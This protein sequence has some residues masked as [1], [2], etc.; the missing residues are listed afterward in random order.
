MKKI[1][2]TGG[3]GFVG[4][5]L[6]NAFLSRKYDVY[7]VDDL[8]NGDEDNINK[9]VKYDKFDLSTDEIFIK[10]RNIKFDAV[11]HCAAQSSN[12][13]SFK[14]IKNDLYSNLV[15]TYNILKLCEYNSINRLI[16]T[17]SM[18]IYGQA[19]ILPTPETCEANPNSY[20][21]INKLFAEKYIRL[22]SSNSNINYTIF[23]LY[24]TYG[25][26]QNL[27]NRNQG[28]LS[29][30]LSY[31]LAN[32]ELIIKGSSDRKR[33]IICVS[34]VVDA[35]V[36]SY[37]S[38]RT[39]NKTYNL[40]SGVTISVKEIINLLVKGLV[41]NP[42][43][44]PIKYLDNTTGDPFETQADMSLLMSDLGWSPKLMPKE[45]IQKTIEFYN[46]K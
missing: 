2:I 6:C 28:L 9:A 21:A 22:F 37:D 8:S 31:I 36:M 20:Y 17:S 43:E 25:V 14:N 35:I 11:V 33:D 12:A 40:G 23:R 45:G 26:G 4:S 5:H 19:N 7:T 30:Y 34:D 15:A 10:Y 18:S 42:N 46:Q 13:L 16:F 39:F 32:D 29:I 41:K 3:A 1:L 27:K 44:Y 24:T 38:K